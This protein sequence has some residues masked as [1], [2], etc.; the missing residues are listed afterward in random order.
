MAAGVA[1]AAAGQ[2]M[3]TRPGSTTR[4]GATSVAMSTG[5]LEV[6]TTIVG[7][8]SSAATITGLTTTDV[9][10]PA[11]SI[12]FAE[13]MT[14]ARHTANPRA[15]A[16][17]TKTVGVALAPVTV[18]TVMWRE[19]M[20]VILTKL[21]ILDVLMRTTPPERRLQMWCRV[22]ALIGG[23][24]R[25]NRDTAVIFASLPMKRKNPTPILKGAVSGP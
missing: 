7:H 25:L 16:T 13:G 10:E 4:T 18:G 2:A 3:R 22:Q 17:M 11:K 1:V 5:E 14:V 24:E 19:D 6:P 23:F 21:A 20:A 9:A 8:P 12:R 15:N